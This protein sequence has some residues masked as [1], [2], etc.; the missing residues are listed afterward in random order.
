[1]TSKIFVNEVTAFLKATGYPEPFELSPMARGVNNR[2]FL[3]RRNNQISA[4]LK[5][6]YHYKG[7]L[8]DRLSSDYGFSR[9]LW[10]HGIHQIPRPLA[11]E[12]LH[13][14]ALFDYIDGKKMVHS[15]I[16]S[17][18]IDQV[19]DFYFAINNCRASDDAILLPNASEACFSLIEHIRLTEMRIQNLQKIQVLSETDKRAEQ[20]ILEE[21][22]PTWERVKYTACKKAEGDNFVLD[23]KVTD[24][25][26][27]LSPSDFGFH[28]VL[29]DKDGA[30]IFMDFEYA[31]W[32]DPAKM[33]CD[34][35]CQPEIPIPR[36]FHLYIREQIVKDLSNPEMQ[37][38]RIEILL[39]VYEIKW[40]CIV[41]NEFLPRGRSRRAFM[42]NTLN[43]EVKKDEQLQ[44]AMNIVTTIRNGEF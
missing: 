41:L 16:T 27:R 34:L 42:K 21:L 33:V 40:C 38:K 14:L 15:E 24:G 36:K 26:M 11:C 25:D 2:L 1:M 4:V 32:D 29:V 7:N 19:L 6:Y 12:P 9:F 13:H 30:L 35:F 23:E 8:R 39:P 44:K 20:F 28:N 22:L 17:Q 18:H 31:G 3:I 37:G 43:P 5:Q 10:D